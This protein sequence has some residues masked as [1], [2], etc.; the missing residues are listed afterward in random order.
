MD[1]EQAIRS[2]RATRDY[3]DESVPKSII[4]QLID[5]AIQAPSAV[6]EQPW[7]FT[8][9]QSRALL[10]KISNQA[11]AHTLQHPPPNLPPHLRERLATPQFDIFYHAP[12]L[13]LISGTTQ[14][15]WIIED[16]A[17]AAANF[18]LSA[19]AFGLGTCW[20]GFAQNWLATPEGKT[21]LH[22]PK[23]CLPVAPIIVG[24]P[25]S[26][27]PAVARGDPKIEWIGP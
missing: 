23:T 4:A 6:N 1:L 5:A 3:V 12:A 15:R 13:V 7:L 10:E 17:L 18:M 9:V 11:I 14:S 21:L 27:A 20:I 24:R 19:C 26:A 16:C 22:L 25:R 8:V 2:R